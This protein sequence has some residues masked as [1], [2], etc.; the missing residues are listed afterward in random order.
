[1]ALAPAHAIL[2]EHHCK[3]RFEFLE[4]LPVPF[5]ALGSTLDVIPA[6]TGDHD[7]LV[8]AVESL[9]HCGQRKQRYQQGLEQ[10]VHGASGV[11]GKFMTSGFGGF[12]LYVKCH[13]SAE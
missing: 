10:N 13:H 6:F 7:Q 3:G 5:I 1:M 12:P 9:G 4:G 11:M 2:A 8:T